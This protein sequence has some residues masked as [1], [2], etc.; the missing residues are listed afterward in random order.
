MR[1]RNMDFS[2]FEAVFA[3]WQSCEGVG[4]RDADSYQGIEKYLLRNP[5]LSFV[6][7]QS[8]SIVATIMGGHD[9]KRGYIQ[10]LAV[11]P[12]FR[13]A[14][15]GARLMELCLAALKSEGILKTHIHVFGKNKR[16]RDFWL[17]RGCIERSDIV[18]FSYINV[19]EGNP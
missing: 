2:D 6:A 17:K 12:S 10:H 7:E 5:G 19:T 14:G 16:A 8:G 3:L 13:K 15:I 18:L 9:G 4:L 11:S 1:Y